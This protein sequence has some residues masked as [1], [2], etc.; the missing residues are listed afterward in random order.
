MKTKTI[1]L[2]GKEYAQ[3]KDRL[4]E[5]RKA[6]ANGLIETKPMLQEDGS[7][8][9]SARILADKTDE[10]SAEATGHAFGKSN[11]DKSFEKLETIAVGRALA[12]LGYASNGEIASTEE[13]EE[14]EQF[15][16]KKQE[17][18]ILMSKDR[19]DDCKNLKELQTVW[20][21]LPVEAKKALEELKNEKKASFTKKTKAE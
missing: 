20:A 11:A 7:I 12:L 2:K 21:E 1:D 6:N 18:M 10:H 16:A 4:Q 17:E 8:I 15:K 9:F 5:F 14:F 3:V 13:M 19:I